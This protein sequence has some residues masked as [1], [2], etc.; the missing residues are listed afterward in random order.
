MKSTIQQIDERIQ[1]LQN[2]ADIIDAPGLRNR[3][4]ISVCMPVIK[5]LRK[6]LDEQWLPIAQ[7]PKDGT[8]IIGASA[9][10]EPHCYYFH[11]TD[12]QWWIDYADGPSWQPTHY[13]PMPEFSK[14]TI[15]P[16]PCSLLD[17]LLEERAQEVM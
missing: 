6:M 17:T 2:R 11:Q 7:A 4:S 10:C 3:S 9:G 15:V 14:M 5:L 12:K 16:T 13:K 8:R 1:E